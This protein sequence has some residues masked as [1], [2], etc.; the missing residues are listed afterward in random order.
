[1]L[2]STI[3]ATSCVAEGVIADIILWRGDVPSLSS[4]VKYRL[5][6]INCLHYC[7]YR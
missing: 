5:R 6:A 4:N 3:K 1:M 7:L 2:N